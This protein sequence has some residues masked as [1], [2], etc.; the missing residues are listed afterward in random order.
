M[1]KIL[2][3][4]L[5]DQGGVIVD[6][7]KGSRNQAHII[8]K[9]MFVNHNEGQAF[10]SR[11]QDNTTNYTKVDYDYTMY[12]LSERDVVVATISINPR[13]KDFVIVTHRSKVTL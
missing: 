11:T 10:G 6:A 7:N 4:D 3:Q 5:I 1:I 12:T 2:I 8:Y 13:N 9:D